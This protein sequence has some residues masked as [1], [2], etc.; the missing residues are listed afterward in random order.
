MVRSNELRNELGLELS[1]KQKNIKQTKN[2]IQNSKK[3]ISCNLNISEAKAIF[4]NVYKVSQSHNNIHTIYAIY[5]HCSIHNCIIF[6][7]RVRACTIL[8]PNL[9]HTL[10]PLSYVTLL[11]FLNNVGHFFGG[12]LVTKLKRKSLSKSTFQKMSNSMSDSGSYNLQ[13]Q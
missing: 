12:M 13:L 6:C 11:I 10:W 2:L 1:S 4:L 5:I 9:L 7:M 8:P 3:V